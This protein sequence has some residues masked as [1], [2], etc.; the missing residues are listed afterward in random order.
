[1]SI[2]NAIFLLDAIDNDLE[3]RE[4][5]Y[6]CVDYSELMEYLKLKGYPFSKD[7]FEEAVS[8]LHVKCQTVENAQLLLQ[9]AE[10]LR[11]LLFINQK[12][13]S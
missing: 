9:K 10:W 12:M 1:M 5:M 6:Q 2:R 3:L 13:A 4:Q 7:E 8:Y 11:F